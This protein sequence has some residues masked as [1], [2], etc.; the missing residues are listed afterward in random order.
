MSTGKRIFYALI[1]FALLLIPYW[2]FQRAFD[3]A[4]SFVEDAGVE[5]AIRNREL[6]GLDA[7]VMDIAMGYIPNVQFAPFYVAADRS[8]YLAEGIS[9]NFKHGFA[10]EII[11]QVGLGNEKFAVTD[12]EQVLI[13][14]SQGIPVVAVLSLYPEAPIGI[15][16]LAQKG[17]NTP[18]DL[19]GKTV[20]VSALYGTSYHT[21]LAYLAANGLT[22]ADIRVLNIGYTQVEAIESG[23][24]DAAVVFLN[25]EKIILENRGLVL[26]TF[27]FA[28]SIDFVGATL[29]TNEDTIK[30]QPGLVRGVV[31]ATRKGMES[32]LK[33]P[34]DA[35]DIARRTIQGLDESQE[36]SAEQRQV[37]IESSKRWIN[38][39]LAGGDQDTPANPYGVLGEQTEAL[40]SATKAAL[41]AQQALGSDV[42]VDAAYTNQ[43]L[44]AEGEAVVGN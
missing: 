34:R 11:T 25:N 10:T 19:R 26:K 21:L 16:A 20:G 3:D 43:F 9:P 14:R 24:V 23:Q 4:Q 42:A 35:F 30:N 39:D 33:Q 18:E 15:V 27:D 41:Q 12:G 44:V 13:A 31:Q 38:S 17:L 28:D 7:Q 6:M 29:I 22:E 8:Y 32:V 36:V 1:L 5:S 37:L 40:W 2:L